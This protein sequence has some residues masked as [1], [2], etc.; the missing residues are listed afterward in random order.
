MTGLL[1]VGASGDRVLNP[2]DPLDVAGLTPL[3]IRF[4]GRRQATVALVD[5]PVDVGHRELATE[6][7][8]EIPGRL[9]GTCV[10]ASDAACVHGTSIAGI[11]TA[12][13]DSTAPGICTGCTLLVRPI[14]TETG[15]EAV[16]LPIAAPEDLAEAITDV[17]EAGAHVINLSIA[18]MR[19]TPRAERA[20]EAVLDYAVRRGVLI[21]AAAG[22]ERS[23]GSSVITRHPGVIPVIACDLFGR[24]MSQSNL[25]PSIGRRGLAAPGHRIISLAAGGGSVLVS[26]TSAAAP[27]VTGTIALLWS[28]FPAA[29]AAQVKH[30]VT[31]FHG[32]ARK[33]VTPPLLDAWAAYRIMVINTARQR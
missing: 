21:V 14:F 17:V 7:V 30:A 4:T 11:L 3:L 8:V 27:F 5:G 26:G 25:G 22:N 1:A 23:F 16:R 6:H 32:P 2:G 24:P 13:R 9:R 19:P 15:S 31:R 28:E 10:R 12:K 20:V 33:T 29:T 18:L